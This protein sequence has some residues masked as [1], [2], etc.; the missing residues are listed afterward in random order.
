MTPEGAVATGGPM[1]AQVN[2]G[3]MAVIVQAMMAG[4]RAVLE[5][6]W[7]VPA[8]AAESRLGADERAAL[9]ALRSRLRSGAG[10][11]RQASTTTWYG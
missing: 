2:V 10:L 6:E 1:G 8:R 9:E 4:G 5:D 7:W 11:L 3:A